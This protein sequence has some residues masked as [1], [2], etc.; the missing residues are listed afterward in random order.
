MQIAARRNALLGAHMSIAGGYHE[1]IE[2]ARAAGCRCVQL[3]TKNNNQ[4]RAKEIL[5]SESQI[6][7]EKL[8]RR[9]ITHP[10]SHSSYLINLASPRDEL[11]K[12]SIDGMVV[13][14]IRAATLGIPYVV[15]HPGAHMESEEDAGLRRATKGLNEVFRQTRTLTTGILLETT[16]G[17]GTCLGHRFEHLR[18]LIDQSRHPERLATCFDTCHVF[19]AGYPLGTEQDYQ[20]TMAAFDA[21]IGVEQIKAFHLNDSAK[22]LGSRVDRHAHIGRGL[23]GSHAFRQLLNDPRFVHVPKYLETPKGVEAGKDLDRINLARLRR[24]IQG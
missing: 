8:V 4:W 3:F 18:T 16:A 7:Q 9:K 15:L 6:F 11:W 5:A 13:E 17:Q 1:A 10:L 21:L 20:A 2:R 24:L 23:I 12:K 22:P 14:V 19:A